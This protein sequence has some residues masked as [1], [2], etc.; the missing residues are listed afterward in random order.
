MKIEQD[1]VKIEG[2]RKRGDKRKTRTTITL[3][4]L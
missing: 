2:K 3:Q 1:N 4:K